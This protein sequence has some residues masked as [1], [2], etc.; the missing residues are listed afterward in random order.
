MQRLAQRAEI[1]ALA[2]T[3]GNQNYIAAGT[4][5]T[6]GGPR[7]SHISALGVVDKAHAAV[8][9]NQLTT[10][11]QAGKRARSGLHR[12]HGQPRSVPQSQ[13]R[14]HIADIVP[15]LN[16]ELLHGQQGIEAQAEPL[17]T[18]DLTQ[19]EAMELGL[20]Q[21]PAGYGGFRTDQRQSQRI[22]AIDHGVG[23]AAKN[24]VFGLV[25]LL[26]TAVPV[27]MICGHI[28]HSRNCKAEAGSALKL[29]AGEF[30]HIQFAL[31]CQ[32]IERRYTEITAHADIEASRCSH[33][34]EQRSHRG[35]GVGAR[36]THHRRACGAHEQVDITTHRG[37]RRQCPLD[38][39]VIQSDARADHPVT[40]LLDD[41][42]RYGAG[43][44][45]YIRHLAL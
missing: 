10:M 14:Q 26:Q 42:I 27:Q 6:E 19:A 9:C 22:I 45:R 40:A 7:G 44:H 41:G 13:R 32:Q 20:L 23:A 11:R 39:R 1:L 25:V 17:L 5:A 37:A 4:K 28:Q 43:K 34:A 12:R 38:Y 3:A 15:P 31:G 29:K 30:Q 18:V 16:A 21:A 24:T 2:D 35:L 36:D 33:F 8:L